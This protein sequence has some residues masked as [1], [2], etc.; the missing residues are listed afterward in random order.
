MSGAAV[1]ILLSTYDGAEYVA[2]QI[3]SIRRQTMSDWTLLVRDDGSSDETVQIVRQ[4]AETDRRILLTQDGGGNLGPAGS[5][6]L[7][8]KRAA[9]AGA[10]YVAL[11]DQDDVWRPDKLARELELLQSREAEV[12][13]NTP[14]LV[15]S[16][17]TVVAE[18]LS[19]V[20]P[21]FLRF[22]GLDREAGAPLGRLLVQNFVTGCTVVLN[23]ALVDVATPLPKVVMHDWWLAL[24]AAALGQLVYLPA[25]TVLYR[26][27][28]RNAAGGRWRWEA[29]LQALRHPTS[30]WHRSADRFSA[31]LDQARELARRLERTGGK[32]PERSNSITVVRDY[33]NAFTSGIGALQRLR[34]V[35]RYGIKPSSLLGY[36]LFFYVRV[37]CWSGEPRGGPQQVTL[38]SP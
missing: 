7:L 2:E 23:R 36:P 24:C 17:L 6:G 38:R 4:L 21:S 1:V 35:R 13:A 27:H 20:H 32:K 34:T 30:W 18:D 5:F 26:Q 31:T 15:H 28:G 19:V 9:E 16:D 33:C 22:Q 29:R 37:L 14:I 8:L 25:P 11:A 12:G 10:C 3:E